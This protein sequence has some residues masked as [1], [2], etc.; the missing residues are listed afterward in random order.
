MFSDATES[1]DLPVL[2]RHHADQVLI[3]GALSAGTFRFVS[4]PEKG[5]IP[6]HVKTAAYVINEFC[7]ENTVQIDDFTVTITGIAAL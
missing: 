7:G 6:S 2:D 3:F 4:A 5:T 1:T